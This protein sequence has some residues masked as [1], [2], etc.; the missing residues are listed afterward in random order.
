VIVLCG[1][2]LALYNAVL[3]LWNVL[4]LCDA[5][6]DRDSLLVAHYR[7]LVGDAVCKATLHAI[8]TIASIDVASARLC[9]VQVGAIVAVLTAHMASCRTPR[10]TRK[11]V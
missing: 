2:G 3:M 10:L 4:V 8:A 6:K 11:V 1:G 9:L 5:C 7:A